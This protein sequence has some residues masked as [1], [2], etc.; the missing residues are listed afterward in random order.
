MLIIIIKYNNLIC[1]L[2][3]TVYPI[4]TSY[5]NYLNIDNFKILL[6]CSFLDCDI[7]YMYIFAQINI[8]III[9]TLQKVLILLL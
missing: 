9:L 6:V 1:D 3:M 8:I 4:L 5:I 2:I 7:L